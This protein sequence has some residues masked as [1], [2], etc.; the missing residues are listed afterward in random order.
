MVDKPRLDAAL[1]TVKGEAVASSVKSAPSL[2]R[3]RKRLASVTFT[4]RMDINRHANLRKL[5]YENET[6]IQAIIDEALKRMGL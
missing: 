6:S 4:F 5:A 2:P 1:M 3:S